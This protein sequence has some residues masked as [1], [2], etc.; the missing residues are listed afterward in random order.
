MYDPFRDSPTENGGVVRFL[1]GN[2]HP[3]VVKR[4]CGLTDEPECSNQAHRQ[5]RKWFCAKYGIPDDSAA[6]FPPSQ[7]DPVPP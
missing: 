3:I 5:M 7:D 4:D 2:P 6:L 1:P